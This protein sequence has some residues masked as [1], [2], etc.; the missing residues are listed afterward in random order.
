MVSVSRTPV[1]GF[2]QP[3]EDPSVDNLDFL[4]GLILKAEADLTSQNNTPYSGSVFQ[5]HGGRASP[6]AEASVIDQGQIAAPESTGVPRAAFRTA[7]PTTE[8]V[9]PTI[10][11]ILH[12]RGKVKTL[13][14]DSLP[15]TFCRTQRF[16]SRIAR[17]GEFHE[18]C[19]FNPIRAFRP[20]VSFVFHLRRLCLARKRSR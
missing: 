1:G 17:I 8:G 5:R 6:I 18:R 19:P 13:A 9:N 11:I 20:F 2:I 15:D 7:T 16:E 12:S 3:T 10:H 4:R 14:P